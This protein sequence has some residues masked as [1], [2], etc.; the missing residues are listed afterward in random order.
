M[1]LPLLCFL[2][3]K[4]TF[5]LLPPSWLPISSFVMSKHGNEYI[6]QPFPQLP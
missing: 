6:K 3:G 5:L 4:E 2:P 1:P